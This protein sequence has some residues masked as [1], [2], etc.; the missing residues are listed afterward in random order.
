MGN[1]SPAIKIPLS[2]FAAIAD[3]VRTDP[4]IK[5]TSMFAFR[6]YRKC[7]TNAETRNERYVCR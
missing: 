4:L 2:T 7:Q 1:Y 5:P 6:D 3:M